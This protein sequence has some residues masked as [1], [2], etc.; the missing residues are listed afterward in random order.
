M[1]KIRGFDLKNY[2]KV[3]IHKQ[4][5]HIA[6]NLNGVIAIDG[7][8]TNFALT[9]GSTNYHLFE[10]GKEIDFFP[11]DDLNFMLPMLVLNQETI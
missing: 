1:S 11:K 3:E 6:T 5:H 8:E 4:G 2:P 10:G 7:I 9:S